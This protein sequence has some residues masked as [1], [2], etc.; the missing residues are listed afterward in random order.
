[1]IL[2]IFTIDMAQKTRILELKVS[3]RNSPHV[4]YILDPI[5]YAFYLQSVKYHIIRLI[6][7]FVEPNDLFRIAIEAQCVIVIVPL[8]VRKRLATILRKH[9]K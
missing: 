9:L 2:N 6:Q 7:L 8:L 4:P 5:T 3:A 1:M